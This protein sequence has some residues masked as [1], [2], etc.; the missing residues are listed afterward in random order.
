MTL[1]EAYEKVKEIDSILNKKIGFDLSYKEVGFSLVSY[2]LLIRGYNKFI[3]NRSLDKN[4]KGED[5]KAIM[6]VNYVGRSNIFSFFAFIKGVNKWVKLFFCIIIIGSLIMFL[7]FDGL[8]YIY[9][10]KNLYIQF[11]YH[12]YMLILL[13]L[14]I[15]PIIINAI[16][17]YLLSKVESKGH[18][19]IPKFSP[20]ILKRFINYL[21]YIGKNKEL[22]NYYKGRCRAELLFYVVLLVFIL[23]VFIY[24]SVSV[25][26]SNE[27][28][29]VSNVSGDQDK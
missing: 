29:D 11:L 27:I 21:I 19:S 28:N 18:I 17:L 3:Y 2:G 20:N 12:Y 14:N 10:Y 6:R 23:C 24:Y 26:F 25:S 1:L 7:Y 4:I 16:I 9:Y 22:L 15:I 8:S 5:L 13:I